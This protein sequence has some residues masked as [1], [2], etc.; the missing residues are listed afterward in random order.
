MNEHYIEYAKS[1]HHDEKIA[2]RAGDVTTLVDE[3]QTFDIALMVDFLHHISDE[4]VIRLL[5]LRGSLAGAI[6]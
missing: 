5:V 1:C 2:F 3:G 4:S 6:S